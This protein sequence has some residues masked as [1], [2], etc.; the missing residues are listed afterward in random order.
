MERSRWQ[1]QPLGL[2][3]KVGPRRHQIIR[4]DVLLELDADALQ[5]PFANR[6]TGA[7]RAQADGRILEGVA[8]P[9]A[10]D[11]ARLARELGL[12]PVD[13]RHDVVDQVQRGDTWIARARSALQGGDQHAPQPEARQGSQRQ[14]E[15][16]RRAIRIGD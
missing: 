3:R 12:L 9:R 10:E 11:L 6:H 4:L 5:M 15:A 14:R 16:N 8:G 13:V 7:L 2:P 1:P